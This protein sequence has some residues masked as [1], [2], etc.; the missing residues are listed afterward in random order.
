MVPRYGR[1]SYSQPSAP[2]VRRGEHALLNRSKAPRSNGRRYGNDRGGQRYSSARQITPGSIDRLELAWTY[3]T[4]TSEGPPGRS[5]STPVFVDGLLYV[6]S[7]LGRVAALDPD[8]GTAVWSFDPHVDTQSNYPDRTNRGVAV[9][10]DASRAA[11]DPCARRV[12]YTPVDSRLIALDA[13]TGKPCVG[14]GT[15]GE[16]DLVA[17]IRNPPSYRGEYAQTSP[18]TIIRDVVVVGS[19]VADNQRANAPSGVVR[20]FDARSGHLRWTWDPV[21]RAPNVPG[22]DTWEGPDAHASGA[23]NVWSIGSADEERDLLFLPTS[24]ASPD[25]YGGARAGSNLY[26]TSVV[27]LRGTTGE[28]VWHFQTVHHDIFDYDVPAQPVLFSFRSGSDAVPAVLQATKMGHVFVLNRLTGEPLLPVEERP[29]PASRVASEKAWPTQ[30]FPLRPPPIVPQQLTAR[31]AWGAT[32]SEREW[33]RDRMRRLVSE[34]IFTPPSLE[35]SIVFPG[36]LGGAHW[37]GA[38][39]DEARDLAIIPTNRLANVITLIP[40]DQDH[41]AVTPARRHHARR[42]DRCTLWRQEGTIDCSERHA[43]QSAAVGNADR[44]RRVDWH[45]QMGNAARILTV[46]EGQTGGAAVGIIRRWRRHTDGERFGVRC[47]HARWSLARVR[48]V[49][50]QANMGTPRAGSRACHANDVPVEGRTPICRYLCRRPRW[51]R[52]AD[53]RLRRRLQP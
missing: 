43:L 17:G 10:R 50:R 6:T 41:A 21:P 2:P 29:V 46:V 12:F 1:R 26:S 35:G 34:G 36:N 7:A 39:V 27:A 19:G 25:F 42:A 33:C 40:R 32:S 4:G 13:T 44:H 23:A 22:Y 20:G 16:V 11:G 48:C 24:S 5:Q 51:V 14:F 45:N 52:H 9:W 30:P 15:N 47:Q 53:R 49:E 38:A 8:L 28:L 37:G 3:R 18:P 31:D